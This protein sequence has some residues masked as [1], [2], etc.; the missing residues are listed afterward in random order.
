MFR[1]CMQAPLILFAIK[2]GKGSGLEWGRKWAGEG[3]GAESAAAPSFSS[4]AYPPLPDT[5]WIYT[6]KSAAR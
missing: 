4:G 5:S 6:C 1:G 3:K 2:L